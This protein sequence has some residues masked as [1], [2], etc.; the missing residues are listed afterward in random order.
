MVA[1]HQTAG[2]GRFGRPWVAPAASAILASVILR[3]RLAPPQAPLVT[4][5]WAAAMREVFARETGSDIHVKWPNDI[6][7]DGAKISGILTESIL[8]AEGIDAMVVGFGV[9]VNQESGL[10]PERATSLALVAG[11]PFKRGVLMRMIL[12]EGARLVGVLEREGPEALLD[13]LR[14]YS[15]VLGRDVTLQAG[16]VLREGR[17]VD[18]D[19]EGRLVLETSDGLFRAAAG[20]V[21]VREGGR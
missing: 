15:S 11:R 16:K 10:P 19:A 2:R 6:V 17:A 4:L 13:P 5:A 1:D 9:N 20:E 21:T 8:G 12:D 3:P 18:I 14:R 7:F